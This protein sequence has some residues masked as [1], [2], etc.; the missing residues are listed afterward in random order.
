MFIKLAFFLC[1]GF[2]EK[3]HH[4]S[5]VS[6]NCEDA[7]DG[8]INLMQL[9]LE[10]K[11]ARKMRPKT[12]WEE[13]LSTEEEAEFEKDMHMPI[14]QWLKENPDLNS[15]YFVK[16]GIRRGYWELTF[17][18]G[19]HDV[20]DYSATQGIEIWAS[21]PGYLGIGNGPHVTLNIE[22]SNITSHAD[23]PSVI[24]DD[25]YCWT[26]GWL[27][28]QGLDG[29]LMSNK[30]AW[31]ALNEQECNKIGEALAVDFPEENHTVYRH[32]MWNRIWPEG[33][34]CNIVDVVPGKTGSVPSFIKSRG[35]SSCTPMTKNNL[36]EHVYRKCLFGFAPTEMAYCNIRGCVMAGAEI[37]HGF[38]CP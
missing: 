19:V 9:A 17:W 10:P 12:Q 13:P 29:S 25:A 36:R 33:L 15:D 31:D 24:P 8:F 11:I 7:G 16:F 34:N 3:V 21:W 1:V 2:A 35:A 6:S 14:K 27:Q 4:L 26:F 30:S 20:T 5:S 23:A 18:Q 37:G 38:E 28:G 32:V 22:G